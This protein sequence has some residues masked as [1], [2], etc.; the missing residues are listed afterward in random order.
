WSPTSP[1]NIPEILSAKDFEDMWVLWWSAIQ[2]KWR[3][4][5]SWPFVQE[6]AAGRGWGSLHKGG[7]DGLFLIIVSLGWWIHAR[8]PSE[9]SKVD[10]AISDVAWVVNNLISFLSADA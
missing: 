3:D 1:M 10:D 9:T 8:D 4:T 6:D 7:K 5:Q 2:P